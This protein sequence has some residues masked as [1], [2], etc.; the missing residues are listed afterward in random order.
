M[1]NYH[2]L[3]CADCV[4]QHSWLWDYEQDMMVVCRKDFGVCVPSLQQPMKRKR[5]DS[6][7]TITSPCEKKQQETIQSGVNEEGSESTTAI[8][9]APAVA[10]LENTSA[11]NSSEQQ[12]KSSLCKRPNRTNSVAKTTRTGN[13]SLFA[14]K[15]LKELL[16]TCSSCTNL[17]ERDRVPFLIHE[18]I[19]YQPQKDEKGGHPFFKFIFTLLIFLFV[20]VAQLSLYEAGMDAL[21]ALNPNEV[22]HQV[23]AFNSLRDDLRSFLAPFAREGKV[24]TSEVWLHTCLFYL[25]TQVIFRT[26]LPSL[27]SR[28]PC[29]PDVPPS[30]IL[31][32]FI[33]LYANYYL[34]RKY[35]VMHC[36]NLSVAFLNSK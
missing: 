16:C 33:C 9:H 21:A 35:I 11:L 14:L 6:V 28:K 8:I 29:L 24:V 34:S 36:H 2:E 13:E 20:D 1:E 10:P 5:S 4:K 12:S 15:P 22:R 3:V 25:R 23:T 27:P 32:C 17:Y 7:D 18:E 19:E 26:L 30:S 31:I